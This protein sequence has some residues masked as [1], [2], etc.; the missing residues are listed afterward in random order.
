MKIWNF[1]KFTPGKF[2]FKAATCICLC[3]EF[4]SKYSSFEMF[5]GYEVISYTLNKVSLRSF[6]TD[7]SDDQSHKE[8]NAKEFQL[9][10]TICSIATD[11]N[12]LDTFRLSRS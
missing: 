2:S 10:G 3:N 5:Q 9:A 6:T 7:I 8:T 4:E 12:S 11:V 1:K